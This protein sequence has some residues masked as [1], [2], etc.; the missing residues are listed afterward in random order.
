MQAQISYEE[1]MATPCIEYEGAL[2]N[3]GYGPHHKLWEK[4]Y[5][6]IEAGFDLHHLCLNRKCINLR[7]LRE[8][9]RALNISLTRTPSVCLTI[10][11]TLRAKKQGSFLNYDKR[12]N[13][14][15]VIF[16]YLS[17]KI[18]LGTYYDETLAKTVAQA[19]KNHLEQ[20]LRNTPT[21]TVTQIRE[22]FQCK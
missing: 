12:F 17:A 22:H 7:H 9:T 16:R 4:V 5:G 2:N 21:P 1:D 3:S 15:Y 11:N 14:W 8:I 6:K 13:C 19:A 10:A 20:Y 18:Y